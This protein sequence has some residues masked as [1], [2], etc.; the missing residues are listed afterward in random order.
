VPCASGAGGFEQPAVHVNQSMPNTPAIAHRV[1]EQQSI[2]EMFKL[3]CIDPKQ[4][5]DH[6]E[7][8]RI[9]VMKTNKPPRTTWKTAASSGVSM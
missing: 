2:W 1:E 3:A 7:P 9:P 4:I 5:R 6:A 8:I